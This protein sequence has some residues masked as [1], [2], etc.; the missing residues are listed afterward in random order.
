[1]MLG[2]KAG[3]QALAEA[4]KKM[5]GLVNKPHGYSIT[6]I[7]DPMVKVPTQILVRKVMWKCCSNEIS[8]LVL[9]LEA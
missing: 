9:D 3:E 5:L 7:S 4:M 2:G 6:S 8:V 1:M